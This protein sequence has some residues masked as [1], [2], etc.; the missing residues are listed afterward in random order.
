MREYPGYPEIVVIALPKCGTKTLNKC[1]TELGYKVFDVQQI[2]AFH[3][4]L[5]AYG[6]KRINFAELAR[7]WEN[8]EFDVI[9]E[10]AGLFWVEMAKHWPKTKLINLVREVGSWQRSLKEFVM[11][12]FEIPD[13]ALIDQILANNNMISPEAHAG[14]RTMESY[15]IYI[16]GYQLFTRPGVNFAE[17]EPWEQMMSR[18]Y[19]MFQAD[20]QVNAPV[21]RTLFNYKLV[22]PILTIINTYTSA[23]KMAGRHCVTFWACQTEDLIFRM[24]IKLKTLR[25]SWQNCGPSVTTIMMVRS[26][27]S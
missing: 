21:E 8:N 16:V 12:Q 17:Q 5:D 6:K 22:N 19:R 26:R 20:V 25:L 1:F 10:P 18:K 13:D 15:V 24:K 4:Q 23:S 3:A 7:I 14:Y 2:P 27:S 11:A 9:I